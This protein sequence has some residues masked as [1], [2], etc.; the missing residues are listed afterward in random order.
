DKNIAKA[1]LGKVYVYQ[2]KW[3]DA[4]PLFTDVL[5]GKDITTMPFENNFDPTKEDGPE[6][7]MVSKHAINSNGAAD[8][9]NVGDMLGGLYGSSPVGC[10]GFYQPTIDLVNAYKVDNQ[11]LPL[12]DKSYRNNEY[13]SE[14]RKSTRLNSSHVKI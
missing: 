8:N 13:K 9:A 12:L 1:Y 3:A 11:G 5:A 10:C 7:L 4:L 14:D 2:K 6:A